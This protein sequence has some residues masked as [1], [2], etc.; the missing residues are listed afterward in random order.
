MRSS[1]CSGRRAFT[2]VKLLAVIAAI[3][4]LIGLMLPAV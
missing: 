4:V 1:S 3:A 2:T